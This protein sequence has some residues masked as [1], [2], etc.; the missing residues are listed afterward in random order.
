MVL[1][2]VDETGDRGTSVKSSPYFAMAAVMFH[3]DAQQYVK[4]MIAGLKQD[5]DIPLD[6]PLHWAHN[7]KDHRKRLHIVNTVSALQGIRVNY[8][9]FDK[10]AAAF[11]KSVL[12]D[13]VRFYNY[14]AGITLERILLCA[15]SASR[16]D[17][18]VDVW[19]GYVKGLSPD[20][21][22]TIDYLSRK[23]SMPN[24]F[25]DWSLLRKSPSFKDA[26]ENSG[27][28]LADM[29]C[30]FLREAIFPNNFGEFE[31]SY[32][33]KVKDQITRR[34]SGDSWGYGFKVMAVKDDFTGQLP[35]WEEGVI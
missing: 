31:P 11:K 1:A 30:G 23:T 27:I 8:V 16:G 10:R 17:K 14:I 22:G 9:I 7:C 25:V 20:K 19:Y 3:E 15:N 32:L 18:S 33:I 35:W 6:K 5:F 26:R 2:F 12:N 4:D 34:P 29:Y 28:Q 21:D 24:S 13:G